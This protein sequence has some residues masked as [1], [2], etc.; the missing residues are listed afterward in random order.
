M[1][2][3]KLVLAPVMEMFTGKGWGH[4]YVLSDNED[5]I[6]KDIKEQIEKGIEAQKIVKQLEEFYKQTVYEQEMDKENNG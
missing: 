1:E 6:E 5:G 3:K 2:D 4:L